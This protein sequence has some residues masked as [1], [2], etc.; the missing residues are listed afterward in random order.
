MEIKTLKTLEFDKILIM[1]ADLA[2]NDKAKEK[3]MALVPS[4]DFRAVEQMQDETTTVV[5][6]LHDV[7][8]D[9]AYTWDDLQAMGFDASVLDALRLLTHEEGVPYMEYVAAIRSNPVARAVKLADLAHNSD[10]S[11]LDTVGE[12]ALKRCEKYAAAIRLLEDSF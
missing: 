8:E 12:K 11:R 2:K 5:A 7:I 3:A 10:L 9:T 6:L 1:L 4:S